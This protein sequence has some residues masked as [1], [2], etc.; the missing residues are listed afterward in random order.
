MVSAEVGDLEGWQ[1]RCAL[2][3]C[4]VVDLTNSVLV[5]VGFLFHDVELDVSKGK[6]KVKCSGALRTPAYR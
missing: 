1:V 6:V 5:P 4:L 3:Y 2:V